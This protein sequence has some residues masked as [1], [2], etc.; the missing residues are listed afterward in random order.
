MINNYKLKGM[1]GITDLASEYPYNEYGDYFGRIPESEYLKD[2]EGYAEVR[3]KLNEAYIEQLKK[4]GK[5]GEEYTTEI[6]ITSITEF[7]DV[8]LTDSPVMSSKFIILNLNN[9]KEVIKKD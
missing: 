6:S 9:D 2:K 5:Y 3:R 8:K 7:D 4:D 1:R